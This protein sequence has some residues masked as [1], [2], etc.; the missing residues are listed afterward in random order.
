ME[1][2]ATPTPPVSLLLCYLCL[3]EAS[4]STIHPPHPSHESLLNLHNSLTRTGAGGPAFINVHMSTWL[5]TKAQVDKNPRLLNCEKY[6]ASESACTHTTIPPQILAPRLNVTFITVSDCDDENEFAVLK[7]C[8]KLA[9]LNPTDLRLDAVIHAE[10]HQLP[11]QLMYC[12]PRAVLEKPSWLFFLAP[13]RPAVW[14]GVFATVA[15]F[16]VGGKGNLKYPGHV[17]LTLINADGLL[18]TPSCWAVSVSAVLFLSYHWECWLTTDLTTPLQPYVF[19]SVK[20]AREHGYR[21]I[22]PDPSLFKFVVLLSGEHV[23]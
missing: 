13:F 17:F 22:L 23:I 4:F 6:F 9:P 7:L 21:V 11:V 18:K 3:G 19:R 14:I 16:W 2:C 20:E 8:E 5:F 15:L 10:T 12:V 1:I